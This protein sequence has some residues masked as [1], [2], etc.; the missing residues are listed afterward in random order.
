MSSS[1]RRLAAR[2]SCAVA[3][4]WTSTFLSAA[5]RLAS[6]M[7]QG[8][9]TSKIRLQSVGSSPVRHSF[10][11]SYHLVG[12]EMKKAIRSP[13]SGPSVGP[14]DFSVFYAE[15]AER[16]LLFHAR[17][18]LDAELAVDLMAETFAEALASR[19]R[20]RGTSEAE[21]AAWLFGIAR[22]QLARFF[23][24]G[25]AER[26]ALKRLGIQVPD[27]AEE[28]LARI[29]ALP[30]IDAMRCQVAD[31]LARL[32]SEQRD[33]LRMRVVE[34]LEYPE[35]ARRLQVSEQAARARVSRGLRQLAAALDQTALATEW[36]RT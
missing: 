25:R 2:A 27:V 28:D 3:A 4:P 21:A 15:Y 10:A 34:E 6:V 19:R 33:A 20:F 23:R 31:Q 26:T 11:G 14:V 12:D 30:D 35:V 7:L 16:V 29:E 32:S 8:C 17:R 9:P 18:C 22:N 5:A 1:S 24:R 13:A 36:S